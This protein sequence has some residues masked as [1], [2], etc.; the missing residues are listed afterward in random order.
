MLCLDPPLASVPKGQWFCHTCLFGTGGDFGFDEGEEHS[1]SSFQARDREFRRMWFQSHPPPQR[2]DDDDEHDP[3]VTQ[4]GNVKVS[5]YDAENE[6][7]RLVQSPHDTVEI[8]YGADVHST[9]HGSA[10]PTLETHPLDPYSKDPWN[11]NN[12]SILSDSLLR[13]IKSDISG[14]TVPW[15][16]VG[17]VFSTFCWHNEDHYTYS[18]NFMHWGETKTWYGIPGEDAEK[19]EAAIKR[20]A[21]DLFE[22]QPD[23]LFQLVTLMNPKRLTDAGV[24]VYACNQRAGEFVITYPKAYHAGFNHGLN[25]NEAVNFALPDWLPYGRQCVQRYREH[26]KL[27]VFSHDELL[28]TITQQSQSIPTAIWLID[29]LSEMTDRELEDRHKARALKMVEV[30]EEEDRLEDQYQCNVCNVF[31]YLSQVTCSCTTKVVCVEHA[32]MLCKC[33]MEQRVLRKRFSD[34]HLTE[35]RDAVAERAA[36]PGYW[37]GKLDKAL[38]ESGRPP[39]RTLRALLAEGDRIGYDFPELPN[40]RKCVNRANEWLDAANGFIVRKQ[41]RKRSRKT[42]EKRLVNPNDPGQG[43]ANTFGDPGGRPD[44]GLDELYALL[45]EVEDLGFDCPEIGVLKAHAAKAEEAKKRAHALLA[46]DPSEEERDTYIQ[47][48]E[49]LLLDASSINV[50]LDELIDVEKLVA[51]EQLVKELENE[52][53]DS[54]MTLEEVS[55]YLSR[56]RACNLP[57]DNKHLKKLE[58]RQR[59]GQ[60]WDE[61]AKHVLS[62]PYKTIEELDEF[63]DMDATV[64]IDPTILDRIGT[65]RLKAKEFEKQAKAWLVAEPG[66]AKPRVQD[67]M[68]LVT[69]AEKDFNIPAVRE[70][71]RMADFALDLESRC[72]QVLKNTYEHQEEEEDVFRVMHR[73]VDYAKQH[74]DIFSLPKFEKLDEQLTLHYRWLEGLPWYCAEHREAH[75]SRLFEDVVEST[76]PE[77]DHPPDDEFFTCIC[78]QAV[79]P[80]AP[81]T[82]SDAVQCDHCF[83]R[84]HGQCARSGGS[85]P[86]CDHHHWNGSIHKERSWHFCYM[87]TMLMYAPEITKN[88]SQDWKELEIIVHRVDRLAAVIGQ[89]LSFASQPG[90]QRREYISQVRHFMRKL[91]KIQFAVSPNP[92]VSFGL[93]LAGLHRIVAGQPTAVRTKKRRRPKF[94]FGQDIDQDWLDGTRCIC[95]GRT[96]YLLN[97]PTVTCELCSKVYHGG[98]VFFPVEYAHYTDSR[99]ICPLCCLRKNRRYEYAELRVKDINTTDM[100]TY[101]DTAK[102]LDLFSKDIIYKKL[103][104]PYTQTLFVELIR[105]TAGQPDSMPVNG[106]PSHPSTSSPVV[107]PHTNGF[108]HTARPPHGP[109]PP[110]PPSVPPLAYEPARS[111]PVSGHQMPPPPP[112]A[113]KWTGPTSVFVTGPPTA[114]PDGPSHALRTPPPPESSRKR[115]LNHVDDLSAESVDDSPQRF[116]PMIKRRTLSRTPVP[117]PSSS[118]HPASSSHTGITPRPIQTLSPSLAMLMSPDTTRTPPRQGLSYPVAGPSMPPAHS[119]PTPKRHPSLSPPPSNRSVARGWQPEP[120]A[121]R[122]GKAKEGWEPSSTTPLPPP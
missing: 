25:F 84:F 32:A 117:E 12:I 95:R 78:D 77:D 41:S 60:S 26:R 1:L 72:D 10:M 23:L 34:E 28:I 30:L 71:K 104:P 47:E 8:E 116:D 93:D 102:M 79:R 110:H 48:C 5:E 105:F 65:A 121:L 33:A 91:Y 106:T 21:P 59:A 83:A 43:Q 56:A 101:V 88:Y 36:V 85:C 18:I 51:R 29:S 82:V 90:N 63:G 4:F 112:W 66:V 75:G 70:L 96:P 40:I 7:W 118:S 11:L 53:D 74:L 22:V 38:K 55:H 17:M 111:T 16:Y 64:P 89:F 100:E 44:K 6:F 120:L 50:C 94:Q 46:A 57:L 92:E 97:Y 80:P 76:R 122:N 13:Y 69:R 39:L 15:T 108:S 73:W 86:F 24:R 107:T 45:E 3:T 19:F 67:V 103:P 68:R 14:M 62:Q 52:V 87:P 99:F 9:T 42:R 35:T 31:C 20:E 49:R 109:P 115:K 58:A 37:K 81:G 119:P 114:G 27:P 98:C 61:R 113:S 2:P 54:V